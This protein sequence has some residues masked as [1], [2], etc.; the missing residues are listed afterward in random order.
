MN[1]MVFH[2]LNDYSGSPKV[3]SMVVRGL[4]NAGHNVTLITSRGGVLDEI[5][6]PRLKRIEMNYELR[7]NKL[8]HLWRYV[9]SQVRMFSIA[10]KNCK[11]AL[12]LINTIL[13]AGAALGAATYKNTPIVCHC[14]EYAA[15]KGLFY[16]ILQR[17]M[18]RLADRLICVSE[19][20]R[21]HLNNRKAVIVRNGVR[22]V[23]IKNMLYHPKSAFDNPNVLMVACLRPYKGIDRF[24]RLASMM[25]EFSFTLV[26]SASEND[27]EQFFAKEKIKMPPNLRVFGLQTDIVPF[28]NRA[29]VVVNLSGGK[30]KETFGLTVAEGFC[31]GLPAIVP[32]CGGI[33]ELV[34]DGIN[35]Y[36]VDVNNLELIKLRLS[37]MFNNR[38]LYQQLSAAALKSATLYQEDDMVAGVFKV[39]SNVDNR[40]RWIKS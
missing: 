13:P 21:N 16:R 29:S 15:G 26:A 18:L 17:I 35:G 6:S 4:L 8:S 3:L 25:P 27:I 34:Q 23:E 1:I 20:Q 37:E 24:I 40:F 7:S 9:I 28:Y 22:L 10:R 12:T 11:G 32:D 36:K 31:A 5:V 2:L 38:T 30:I 14:H 39:L 19:F 33:S